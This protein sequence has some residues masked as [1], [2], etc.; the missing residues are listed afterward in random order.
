MK[1]KCLAFVGLMAGLTLAAGCASVPQATVTLPTHQAGEL[2][3]VSF[4]KII[5]PRQAFDQKIEG[6]VIIQVRVNESG[7]PDP[8]TLRIVESS[9]P[10]F[11]AEALR[12]A[13]ELRFSLPIGTDGKPRT[14]WWRQPI[15]FKLPTT[16]PLNAAAR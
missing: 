14:Q 13:S 5:Y 7:R 16:A 3:V 8:A 6:T 4:G 11:N 15:T 2:H 12:F 1:F 9:N 10:L